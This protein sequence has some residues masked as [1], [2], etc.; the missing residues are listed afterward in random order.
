V[1]DI[2]DALV[3]LRDHLYYESRTPPVFDA[4]VS[5]FER[6]RSAQLDALVDVVGP[7]YVGFHAGWA[8]RYRQALALL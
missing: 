2:G 6:N 5:F 1:R 3:S 4:G 8:R 7:W